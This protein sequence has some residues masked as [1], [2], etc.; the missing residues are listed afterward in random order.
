MTLNFIKRFHVR[1]HFSWDRFYVTR[2]LKLY[3]MNRTVLLPGMFVQ[4]IRVFS[5]LYDYNTF[6]MLLTSVYVKT[7]EYYRIEIFY[8]FKNLRVFCVLIIYLYG[9]ISFM[10]HL[11]TCSYVS[12]FC[13]YFGMLV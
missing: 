13:S 3:I 1:L 4:C 6:T 12:S 8:S 11:C 7:G 10:V 2:S 9:F 5:F